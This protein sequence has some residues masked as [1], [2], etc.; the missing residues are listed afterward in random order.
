MTGWKRFEM[1]EVLWFETAQINTRNDSFG[2]AKRF[3]FSG[4]LWPVEKKKN[5][6]DSFV[7]DSLSTCFAKLLIKRKLNFNSSCVNAAYAR[8]ISAMSTSQSRLPVHFSCKNARQAPPAPA[9]WQ[10]PS[11]LFRLALSCLAGS[12]FGLPRF[13]PATRPCSCF[14]PSQQ[15]VLKYTFCRPTCAASW[16]MTIFLLQARLRLDECSLSVPIV[17]VLMSV[18]SECKMLIALPLAQLVHSVEATKEALAESNV[19]T[20]WT[21]QQLRKRSNR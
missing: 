11:P 6:N 16:C 19:K 10:P 8:L 14:L 4:L 1:N 20:H 17:L 9:L 3:P 2:A 18:A 12:F 15:G 21:L 5:K 13:R 7:S